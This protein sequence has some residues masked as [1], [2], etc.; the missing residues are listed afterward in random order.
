MGSAEP[1]PKKSK[2]DVVKHKRCVMCSEKVAGNEQ[3][4]HFSQQHMKEEDVAFVCGCGQRF[5]KKLYWKRHVAKSHGRASN[6]ALSR[7]KRRPEKII[8]YGQY[9]VDVGDEEDGGNDEDA[10]SG[11]FEETKDI[12]YSKQ[13][14][15]ILRR[16]QAFSKPSVKAENETQKE[17]VMALTARGSRIISQVASG[18]VDKYT[19]LDMMSDVIEEAAK[20]SG[21]AT[22][23]Y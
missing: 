8:D 4:P 5:N 16:R 18:N 14:V 1:A 12:T 20:L 15:E 7:A 11:G 19:G 9:F 21:H 17:A 3:W 10:Q 23:H 6:I 2:T 13:D 22:S